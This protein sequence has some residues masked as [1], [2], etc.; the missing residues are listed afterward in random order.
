MKFIRSLLK[1]ELK[2]KYV[3]Y[4]LLKSKICFHDLEYIESLK[5]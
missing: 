1:N 5:N 2:F 3:K 4:I